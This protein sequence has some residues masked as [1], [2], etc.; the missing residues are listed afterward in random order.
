MARPMPVFAPV[1]TAVFTLIACPPAA[2]TYPVTVPAEITAQLMSLV[3]EDDPARNL[4]AI[5]RLQKW[6]A[7]A[8]AYC[9]AQERRGLATRVVQPTP[10]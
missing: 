4:A 9:R 8:E 2:D 7:D 6:L 1:T 3:R 10:R 5:H